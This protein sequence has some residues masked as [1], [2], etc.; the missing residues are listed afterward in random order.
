VGI[1]I[2]P[3]PDYALIARSCGGYG[4]RVEEPSE[5]PADIKEA[6]DIVK[7]GQPAVLDV[8]IEKEPEASYFKS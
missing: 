2:E 7:R 4:R 6:L 5:I 3:S 8:I 1:D